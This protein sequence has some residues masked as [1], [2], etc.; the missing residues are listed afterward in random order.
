[1]GAGVV[2]D[3][4]YSGLGSNEAMGIFVDFQQRRQKRLTFEVAPSH[5]WMR[6]DET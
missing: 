5:F 4:T 6:I 1:M 2:G 3:C